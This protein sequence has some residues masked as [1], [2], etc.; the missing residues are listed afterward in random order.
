M[1]QSP[2]AQGDGA[3]LDSYRAGW[4]ALNTMLS[5]GQS[6][7]GRERNCVYLN[8]GFD[9]QTR[10][11][12]FA[13]IS[14]LSGFDYPD[15]ARGV[16]LADWDQD[17]DLD[18]WVSNR[19]APRLRYLDNS[20]KTANRS[21][22]LLLEGTTCNRDA[23]GTRVVMQTDRRS[24]TR[25]VRAGDGY[26]SQTSKWLHFGLGADESVREVT[27]YWPGGEREQVTGISAGGRF[28]VT[29]GT[30]DAF[31]WQRRES[32]IA[33]QHQSVAP[34]V[35]FPPE[36]NAQ[37]RLP[38][39]IPTPEL[40]YMQNG[41]SKTIEAGQRPLLVLF[42]ASWCPN[43]QRELKN[44]T[45]EDGKIRAAGIDILALAVDHLSGERGDDPELK[46]IAWPFSSG[47]AAART[48]EKLE[49][50]TDALF[51]VRTPFAVPYSLLLDPA[52][53]LVSIYRGA[54]PVPVLVDDARTATTEVPTNRDLAVPFPGKWY[55][56]HPGEASLLELLA[57]HFQEPFPEDA[58]RYLEQALP[59]LAEEEGQVV[60][61]RIARLHLVL[62]GRDFA[63]GAH[64]KA[65]RH[66]L[67]AHSAGLE[68]ARSHHDLGIAL[69]SQGKL[70]A[71]EAAFL[72]SLE[73]APGNPSATT[74]L[75]SVRRALQD[76]GE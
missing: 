20:L 29:Q 1:S 36:P 49:H 3:N 33:I 60:G 38:R 32:A 51:E 42:F 75:A 35:G 62:A 69:F 56:L 72:R 70:R 13:N 43:C 65:E 63:Q 21:V 2:K 55:T 57:D 76:R 26:L 25:S 54:I 7:S 59:N 67:A 37:V 71:S 50:L 46:D 40:V 66:F 17:G 22:A 15:D 11:P 64:A 47:L 53:N 45:K 5:N 39:V 19:T 18:L 9:K 27:F 48:L 6:F 68:S 4:K 74:N 10:H 52:R 8:S 14:A 12:R 23:V 58:L 41:M 31:F 61:T 30:G 34:N 73:L 44:L 28:I 16:A 24:L